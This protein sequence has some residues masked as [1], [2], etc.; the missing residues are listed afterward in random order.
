[1]DKL[2]AVH[3][4]FKSCT[5]AIV[6]MGKG[7]M[8]SVFRK[9]KLNTRSSKGA[10]LVDID[11][12]SVF[13]LWTVLFIEWQGYK[14]NKKILYKDNNCAIILGVNVKSSAGKR[15]RLLNICYFLMTYQV[16]KVNL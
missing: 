14:N 2:F 10:E 9:Q 3:P 11:D 13:I 5:K 12:S 6:T 1:M 4:Y 16:E 7:A 15:I 8:R